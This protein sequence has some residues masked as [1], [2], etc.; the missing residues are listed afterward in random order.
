MTTNTEGFHIRPD[1]EFAHSSTVTEFKERV[2]LL[3]GKD[4]P[5]KGTIK[6]E[7]VPVIY[8]FSNPALG[9]IGESAEVS[10][11]YGQGPDKEDVEG[12]TYD[13][14][15][16]IRSVYIAVDEEPTENPNK[17]HLYS[18]VFRSMGLPEKGVLK[19][20]ILVFVFRNTDEMS[21][22]E[23]KFGLFNPIGND[24]GNMLFGIRPIHPVFLP[25][26]GESLSEDQLKFLEGF[27]SDKP[28]LIEQ[29]THGFASEALMRHILD[30]EMSNDNLRKR[31]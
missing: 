31:K 9:Q 3:W 29:T 20:Q 15:I 6:G 30:F 12:P 14:F 7:Y 28:E 11:L 27:I 19:D 17:Q 8:Y 4:F 26:L 25:S 13:D 21:K 23:K 5:A 2:N 18:I 10:V 22:I 16:L 24:F 1:S